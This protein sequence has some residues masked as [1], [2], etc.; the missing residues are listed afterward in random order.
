MT[1]T[2][3]HGDIVKSIKSY[4]RPLDSENKEDE[5]EEEILK[6]N[7]RK[8]AIKKTPPPPANT[9]TTTNFLRRVDFSQISF[10]C[11]IA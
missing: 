7:N 1:L 2:W 3:E 9:N 10:V 5:K 4:C 11:L 6:K 8:K